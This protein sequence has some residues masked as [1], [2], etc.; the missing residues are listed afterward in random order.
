MLRI[1]PLRLIDPLI[2]NHC[3]FPYTALF[4]FR[5]ELH[6]RLAE[7]GQTLEWADVIGDLD[8]LQSVEVEQDGKRFLLRSEI[9]GTCGKVFQAVRVALPPTVQQVLPTI[10]GS[11]AAHS[12]TPPN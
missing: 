12:A 9:Q 4:R 5:Q 7:R 6:S 11:N 2:L 8:R 1:V 3:C 10:P